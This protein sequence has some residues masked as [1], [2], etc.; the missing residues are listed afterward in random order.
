MDK[1][2]LQKLQDYLRRLFGNTAVTVKAR[3]KLKDSA[4]VFI[5]D[6]FIGIISLDEEDGDRSYAFVMS[7]LDID[8]ED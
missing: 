7:I 6:E 5:G 3:P 1:A 8:L 4:E 2:E